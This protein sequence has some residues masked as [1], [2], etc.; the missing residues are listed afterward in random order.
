MTASAAQPGGIGGGLHEQPEEFS[1]DELLD[2]DPEGVGDVLYLLIEKR[3]RSTAEVATELA[4]ALG[5][6]HDAVRYAEPLEIQATARQWFSVIGASMSDSE[7]ITL[8]QALI[9]ARD[10]HD[11]PIAEASPGSKRYVVRVRQVRATDAI[12]AKMILDQQSELLEAS[13]SGGGDERGPY[14]ELRFELPRGG[15][16]G[17]VLRAIMGTDVTLDV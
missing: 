7:S 12:R 9:L 16:C 1:V 15:D 10:Q 4:T 14:V 17:A 3:H 5:L 8:A 13:A 11:V 2:A 6:P